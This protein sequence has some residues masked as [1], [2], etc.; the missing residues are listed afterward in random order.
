M[1]PIKILAS[2]SGPQQALTIGMYVAVRHSVEPT[3]LETVF[4]S[5]FSSKDLLPVLVEA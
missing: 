5:N 1:V 4:A 3:L 2:S